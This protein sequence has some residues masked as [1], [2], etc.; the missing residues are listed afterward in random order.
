M[1]TNIFTHTFFGNVQVHGVQLPNFTQHQKRVCYSQ[2][3]QP[4]LDRFDIYLPYLCHFPTVAFSGKAQRLLRLS[5]LATAHK[6][7]SFHPP[8]AKQ[9]H[10]HQHKNKHKQT[11]QLPSTQHQHKHKNT[12]TNTKTQTSQLPSTQRLTTSTT[13]RQMKNYSVFNKI[14]LQIHLLN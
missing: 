6:L 2:I 8:N 11:S 3:F 7:P 10:K 4:N 13:S 14:Y 9:K 12:N 1:T 5:F